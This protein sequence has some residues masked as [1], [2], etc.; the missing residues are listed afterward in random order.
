MTGRDVKS[1]EL[2]LERGEDN[3]WILISDSL[4]ELNIKDKKFVDAIAYLMNGVNFWSTNPTELSTL[5]TEHS[6][7]NYSNKII[8][9][10]VRRLSKNLEKLDIYCNIRKSNGYRILDFSKESSESSD[11]FRLLN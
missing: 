4:H 8:T 5:I 10:V 6:G 2:E 3:I 11:N 1:R 7:D 9:K